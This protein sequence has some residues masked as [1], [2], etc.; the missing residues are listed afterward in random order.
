MSL[1]A[2]RSNRKDL[3]W[4][5]NPRM[6]LFIF[7]QVLKLAGK[8][9][10]LQHWDALLSLLA[11]TLHNSFRRAIFLQNWYVFPTP[12]WIISKKA[13]LYLTEPLT[14]EEPN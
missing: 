6:A 5:R 3:R 12:T 7:V 14:T 4:F 13:I 2:K 9:P 8:I 1:R 10:A 11:R